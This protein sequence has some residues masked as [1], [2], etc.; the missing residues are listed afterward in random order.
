VLLV[1]DPTTPRDPTAGYRIEISGA[2]DLFENPMNTV[3]MP[4]PFFAGAQLTT[5][6]KSWRYNTTGTDLSN[7]WYAVNFNDSEWPEGTAVFD[8]KRPPRTN[9]VLS[10]EIIGTV[11]TLSNAANTAQIPTHYF[12]THFAH[13]GGPAATVQLRAM[14]DDAAVYYL[15]GVEFFRVGL[16]AAPAPI[17][18]NTFSTR[19][20][21]DATNELFYACVT[22]L[23]SG[24]NVLAVEVHNQSA[25]SSDITFG[26]EMSVYQATPPPPGSR[27]TIT[28]GTTPG[29]VT[30]S[31]TG[32]GT[33]QA[34]TDLGN[35]NGWAAVPGVTGNSFTTQATGNRFF[36]L[37]P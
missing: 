21:G 11:T 7:T 8:A 1:I 12:R 26:S 3:T 25:T 6:N 36:R 37:G 13:S 35:P 30:I 15:N 22:N 23:V 27:L 19:T 29:E 32:S 5:M 2:L 14:L 33:L 10:G 28:R 34:N 17:S 20:V 16:P 18:Y 31:W 4:I 9:N 24:D